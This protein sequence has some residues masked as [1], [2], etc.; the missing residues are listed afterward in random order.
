MI[1]AVESLHS[2]L[3]VDSSIS[4]QKSELGNN[5]FSNVLRIYQLY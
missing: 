3:T 4:F 2:L 1:L 5:V